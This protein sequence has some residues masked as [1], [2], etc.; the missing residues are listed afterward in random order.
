MIDLTEQYN[1]ECRGD[2][3]AWNKAFTSGGDGAA[4]EDSPRQSPPS[5]LSV[6]F[7]EIR[8]LRADAMFHVCL[9]YFAKEMMK[10]DDLYVGSA[11][12]DGASPHRLLHRVEGDLSDPSDTFNIRAVRVEEMQDI[13]DFTEECS[14]I[15]PRY[16]E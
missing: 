10:D 15:Y 14:Y 8:L 6:V 4:D 5:L 9:S 16:V 1:N 7:E 12:I 13:L 2:L 3:L 11:S